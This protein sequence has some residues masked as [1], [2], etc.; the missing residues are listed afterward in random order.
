[1]AAADVPDTMPA[2]MPA[3]WDHLRISAGWAWSYVVLAEV[4]AGNAGVGY[5]VIQSQ[6]YLQ[7]DTVFAGI[8]F[9]GLLGALTDF[10]FRKGADKLFRWA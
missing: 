1:M 4:V 7:T 6:R 3:I 10:A 5:F 8:L 9:I 2:A